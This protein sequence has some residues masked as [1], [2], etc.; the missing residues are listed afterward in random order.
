[1]APVPQSILL[2]GAGELGLNILA[3]LPSHPL[4]KG[5]QIS[6]LLRPDTIASTTPSKKAELDDF[7][8]RDIALVSGDV[9]ND[10]HTKLVSLF[11]QYETVLLATG[12]VLP[13]GTQSR[14]LKAVLEAKVPLYFPWQY[15]V[16]YDAIGHGS[17]QD[18]FAEQLNIRN[19]LRAQSSTDWVIISTGLFMSFLL[20]P[21][22]GIVD[23]EQGVV[24]AL[25]SWDAAVTATTVR[26][27][28]WLVAEVLFAFPQVRNCIVYSAGDTVTYEQLADIVEETSAKKWKRILWD[29]KTL[30]NELSKDPDNGIKKYRVAF[31][32]AKGV[33]W[34]KESTFTAENQMEMMDV[35]TFAISV[36]K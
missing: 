10:P 3:F 11:Q 16:D 21:T 24:H 25:G 2:I 33:S 15:G 1:M 34:P 7:K 27:I 17:A 31:A 4:R 22:F 36:F 28:G 12:M 20:D 14:I 18:L 8:A 19:A 6:V 13:A 32:E 5:R 23:R 35:K 29:M 30:E 26:D 9:V